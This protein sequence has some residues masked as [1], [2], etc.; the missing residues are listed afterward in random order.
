MK[1]AVV[2]GGISGL[3]AAWELQMK[4]LVAS[5]E[6]QKESLE[7]ELHEKSEMLGGV[8]RTADLDGICVEEGADSF[9]ARVPEGV[10]LCEKLGFAQA[11]LV[12]PVSSKVLL[13]T[14][15]GFEDLFQPHILG[16][17]TKTDE[18]PSQLKSMLQADL[19]RTEIQEPPASSD[20]VGAFVRRRVG[21]EIYEHQVA[22]LIGA[23]SASDPDLLSLDIVTPQFVQAAKAS[24]SLVKGLVSLQNKNAAVDAPVFYAPQMGMGSIIDA[25][26][27]RL[28]GSVKLNSQIQ[29]L[30]E[31]QADAVILAVPAYVA[32]QLLATR[33]PEISALL[34]EIKYVSVA[35]AQL[36]YDTNQLP[37]QF[38]E[39]AGVLVAK[40][41]G[42]H[43]TA[44]SFSTQKWG[45]L[46]TEGKTV[47]RVSVGTYGN[48]EIAKSGDDEIY[49]AVLPELTEQFG[50]LGLPSVKR[51][52]RWEKSFPQYFPATSTQK[53]HTEKME[54]IQ[55]ELAEQ[56]IFLAGS[57]LSGVGIPACI[58]SA[59]Q[60][61][62][63]TCLFFQ[64]NR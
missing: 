21:D 23:I 18:L 57:S 14:K 28:G 12:S 55:R 19:D 34:Q 15:N 35:M 44:I 49:S 4:S 24:P 46:V 5:W 36:I 10:E 22:P 7:V 54:I 30:E 31:L 58:A 53:G 47:L 48:D 33:S 27:E 42:L 39:T 16:V 41:L 11:D 20:T 63:A 6:H 25:L 9:L 26:A 2:G 64:K 29:N 51:I 52:S 1:V 40:E 61:V 60:A 3:V 8:I 37:E 17:P 62:D 13:K 38:L 59:K 56:G 50:I 32:A 45:H 43:T